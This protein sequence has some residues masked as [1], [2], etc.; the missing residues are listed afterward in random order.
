MTVDDELET[1]F[2]IAGIYGSVTQRSEALQC[3]DMVVRQ[4]HSH[5]I[6]HEPFLSSLFVGEKTSVTF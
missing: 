3:L 1:R 2:R 6:G 5:H 4:R